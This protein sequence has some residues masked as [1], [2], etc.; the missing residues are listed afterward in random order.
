MRVDEWGGQG[1]PR[2]DRTNLSQSMPSG[3]EKSKILFF[4]VCSEDLAIHEPQQPHVTPSAMAP[5]PER[6]SHTPVQGRI[7][8][9]NDQSEAQEGTSNIPSY[10]TTRTPADLARIRA[11]ADVIRDAIEEFSSINELE[12]EVAAERGCLGTLRSLQW[13]GNFPL[14]GALCEAAAKGGQLKVLKWLLENDCPWD[15]KAC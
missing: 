13:R 3:R 9:S 7:G 2:G 4:F 14:Q 6:S 10:S 15:E 8:T 1:R 5:K 11:F 12:P